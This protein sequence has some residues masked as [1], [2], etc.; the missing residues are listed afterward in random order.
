MSES[1]LL[2]AT[3][4][5]VSFDTVSAHGNGSAADFLANELESCGLEVVFHETSKDPRQCNL[6][7]WS[8]PPGADGLILSGHIDTVPFADQPGWEVEPLALSARGDRLIGRGV[9]DM[10]GF[11]AQCLAALRPLD[12]GS[13]DRPVGSW[14]VGASRPPST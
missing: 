10:K 9:T 14:G 12:V 5:L 7:A 11:L 2:D 8:G 6:V 13:L 4:K 3:E 1:Y